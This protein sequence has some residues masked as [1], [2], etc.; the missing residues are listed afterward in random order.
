MPLVIVYAFAEQ[1]EK[2][3]E[4][5]AGVDRDVA[6]YWGSMK[7]DLF[8]RLGRYTGGIVTTAL[9]FDPE[10]M[11]KIAIFRT[12]SPLE[13]I[14]SPRIARTFVN[15]A[16][17]Y[18]LIEPDERDRLLNLFARHYPLS[19]FMVRALRKLA[20]SEDPPGTEY[21]RSAIY[22]L[23]LAAKRALHDDPYSPTID[24]KHLS[25]DESCFLGNLGDAQP[26]WI[27]LISNM[28]TA[29]KEAEEEIRS[30]CEHAAK[31]IL[32]KGSTANTLALLRVDDIRQSE[33]YGVTLGE[34]QL[35]ALLTSKPEGVED[36][37]SLM[38][39][40]VEYL[41]S[42]SS[43]IEERK[44]GAEIYYFPA[45]TGT[46]FSRLQAQ[47][48]EEKMKASKDR[49]VYLRESRLLSQVL[50]RL[51]ISGA[52]VFA[53]DLGTLQDP[54]KLS[55]LVKDALAE[56]RPAI[57]LLNI[58]DSALAQEIERIGFTLVA[59]NLASKLNEE[60][61]VKVLG[62]P[63][64][65]IILLPDVGGER[66]RPLIEDLTA[67]EAAIRFSDYL[68]EEERV[69][70][71]YVDRASVLE[72]VKRLKLSSQEVRRTI[73]GKIKLEIEVARDAAEK[74]KMRS[75]RGTVK[76]LVTLYKVLCYD[77]K[78]KAFTSLDVER[79]MSKATEKAEEI[80]APEMCADILGAFLNNVIEVRFISDVNMIEPKLMEFLRQ[81]AERGY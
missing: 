42:S 44:I 67:Y 47:L 73:E 57:V 62:R 52:S 59:S 79:L 37:L 4:H 32:S 81:R 48:I 38:K 76:K 51:T 54:K 68:R 65:I 43:S 26:S 49:L 72:A 8:E 75:A 3:I 77:L 25:L 34:L 10:D 19:P 80:R 31:L 55:T 27:P 23:A 40:G 9:G 6:H 16:M 50:S 17:S 29:T 11:I 63:L 22:M 53:T 5:Y 56:P 58:H 74:L 78:K 70:R 1:D 28:T 2:V 21:V 30:S 33:R 60:E 13:E 64:Y 12:I 45:L 18:S 39:R 69:V 61:Y 14:D 36:A 41:V 46:V 35:A 24:V 71:E 15:L 20:Q 7:V 66:L